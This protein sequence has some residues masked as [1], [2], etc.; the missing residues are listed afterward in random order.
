MKATMNWPFNQ[1]QLSVEDPIAETYARWCFTHFSPRA[2]EVLRETI[3]FFYIKTDSWF[4]P[5]IAQLFAYHIEQMKSRMNEA[6]EKGELKAPPLGD[7]YKEKSLVIGAVI[8]ELVD[9]HLLD[10]SQVSKTK[11]ILEHRFAR[12]A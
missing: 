1:S 5:S 7:R 3:W 11:E 9:R 10:G 4:N 6:I 8:C 2:V 12:T